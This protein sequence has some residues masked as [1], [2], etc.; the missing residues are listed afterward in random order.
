MNFAQ[1]LIRER[2][3]EMT[4]CECLILSFFS[5]SII[6]EQTKYKEQLGLLR[7]YTFHFKSQ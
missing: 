4:P 1:R 3:S 7:Y 2:D 5:K 6:L